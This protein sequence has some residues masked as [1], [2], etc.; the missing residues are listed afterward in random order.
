MQKALAANE[1]TV[2][3]HVAKRRKTIEKLA[4]GWQKSMA[5]AYEKLKAQVGVR[6]AP[7]SR[8][9]EH[10]QIQEDALQGACQKRRPAQCAVC[11]E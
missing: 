6:G 11:L 10:L 7:V 5:Q 1:Q 3:W 2:Q 8:R 9:Q 4:D